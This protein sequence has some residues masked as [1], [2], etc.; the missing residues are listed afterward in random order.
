MKNKIKKIFIILIVITLCTTSVSAGQLD[1][2]KDNIEE[3]QKQIRESEKRIKE[4]NNLKNDAVEYMKALD[5]QITEC[6]DKITALED[7]IAAVEAKIETTKIEL[8]NAKIEENH[9]Y[10]LAKERIKYMYET[11][12]TEI[13]D[14][15]AGQDSLIS[16]FNNVDYM[17]QIA[18]Y[19]RNVLLELKGIKEDIILKEEQLVKDQA[20]LDVLFENASIQKLELETVN[21]MKANELNAYSISIENKEAAIERYKKELKEEEEL[22]KRLFAMSTGVYDGG[23]MLW[24][25]DGYYTITS[26]FGYRIH[27]IYGKGNLHSGT[28]IRAPKGTPILAAYSG[29]VVTATLNHY[30]YGNYIVIDHGSGYFTLYAHCSKLV[31]SVGDKVKTGDVIAKVGSTGDST[32]NHLHFSYR[33]DGKYV[34]PTQYLLKP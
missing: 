3:K 22:Y 14:V 23:Q 20:D 28:D 2:V 31:A 13:W 18:E 25:L 33:K 29:K 26:P 5:K 21:T 9:Q 19:D 1:D 10:N 32:G 34:E 30:S 24:P 6:D 12:D 15:I 4:L 8:E 7:S 11:G 27:P 16:V 17:Q